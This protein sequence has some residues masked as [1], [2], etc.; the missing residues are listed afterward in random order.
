MPGELA[1]AQELRARAAETQCT[2]RHA[3]ID[4]EIAQLT[5]DQYK[6]QGRSADKVKKQHAEAISNDH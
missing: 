3:Q 2:I 5:L 4:L 1:E 6:S